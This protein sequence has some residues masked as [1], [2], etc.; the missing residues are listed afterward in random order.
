MKNNGIEMTEEIIVKLFENIGLGTVL[1]PISPVSGGF[2]HKIFKVTAESGVF[3]VKRLNPEIM[4]RPDAMGNFKAAEALESVL[5][6]AGIPIVP[7]LTINGSKLQ[8]CFGE[9]FYV[10]RWQKGKVAEAHDITS[11]QC[12]T[13]GSILGRIQAIAP[14]EVQ[15][16]EPDISRINWSD[17]AERALKQGSRV[18]A[19]LKE[20][21]PLIERAQNELNKARAALPGIECIV[22]EDMDPKNVLWDG[23]APF[24]IDLECLERGNPVSSAIQLSL[25]WAG[26]TV[27][28]LDFEKLKAFFDGYLESYD[29][30]FRDYAAVFGL[31]Y[32]WLEWLE[33]N[34]TRALASSLDEAERTLGL[35]EVENTIKK[36]R[37]LDSIEAE[38]K[39]RLSHWFSPSE[40]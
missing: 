13:A 15:K 37:Y 27:F 38:V 16:S 2:L 34:V 33:Y 35:S 10:F 30:G 6:E 1:L 19:L 12:R 40:A 31:S 39:R 25:Q 36:I 24:V 28:E 5:E 8:E 32:I 29:N 3:A 14:C 20:N 4:R 18:G 9:H 23:G 21:E 17:H 22:N 7:A 11:E 26:S